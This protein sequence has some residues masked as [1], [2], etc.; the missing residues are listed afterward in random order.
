MGQGARASNERVGLEETEK[1]QV[2]FFRG[3]SVSSR[4]YL[5]FHNIQRECLG[6]DLEDVPEGLVHLVGQQR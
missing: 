2:L 6:Q 1:D 3:G 4:V 5:T